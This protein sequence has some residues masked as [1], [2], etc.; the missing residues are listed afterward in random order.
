MLAC[1]SGEGGLWGLFCT[2]GEG[3]LE[4]A[5]ENFDAAN[6]F[7][8]GA[9]KVALALA[10]KNLGLLSCRTRFD[11]DCAVGNFGDRLEASLA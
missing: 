10:W 9:R 2:S 3:C 5:G 1:L 7:A 8:I 4:L 11:S 6:G